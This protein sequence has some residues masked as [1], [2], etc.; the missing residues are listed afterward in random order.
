MNMDNMQ[1]VNTEEESYNHGMLDNEMALLLVGNE[2]QGNSE[3]K[4]ENNEIVQKKMN[5][6]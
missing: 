2:S 1:R 4:V 5:D 6:E 3:L